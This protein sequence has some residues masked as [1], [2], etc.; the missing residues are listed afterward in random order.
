MDYYSIFANS[1]IR[2]DLV[3]P[4]IQ[5]RL[6]RLVYDITNYYIM[7]SLQNSIYRYNAIHV[8]WD[9]RQRFNEQIHVSTGIHLHCAIF[10]ETRAGFTSINGSCRHSYRY[11]RI[12]PTFWRH[13]YIEFNETGRSGLTE[14]NSSIY[15]Q[16]LLSNL[17]PCFSPLPSTSLFILNIDIWIAYSRGPGYRIRICSIMYSS[18]LHR[19][20]ET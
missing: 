6:F 3:Y 1:T 4:Q 15:A 5:N 12:K 2:F 9:T 20:P 10:L 8:T 14:V 11:G 17:F 7:V 13:R 16:A 19:A 18:Y